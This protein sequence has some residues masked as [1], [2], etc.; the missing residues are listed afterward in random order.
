MKLFLI[1]FSLYS[2]SLFCDQKDDFG[3]YKKVLLEK[4]QKGNSESCI[5]VGELIEA[6]DNKQ[7][8]YATACAEDIADACYKLSK[9]KGKSIKKVDASTEQEINTELDNSSLD[10][11]HTNIEISGASSMGFNLTRAAG[12]TTYSFSIAA[13]LDFL[14]ANNVQIGIDPV[15]GFGSGDVITLGFMVGPTFNLPIN[16]DIRDAFFVGLGAGLLYAKVADLSDTIFGIDL[17]FGKRFPLFGN[18]VYKPYIDFTFF[19]SPTVINVAFMPIS[20][21]GFF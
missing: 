13:G 18:F 5:K 19:F 16:H 12:T 7:K 4:C 1:V 15:I 3:K 8:M 21:A 20:F 10:D 2:A 11:L 14:V 17:N 6:K 9:T